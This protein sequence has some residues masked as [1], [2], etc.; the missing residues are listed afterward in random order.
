MAVVLPSHRFHAAMRHE[1]FLGLRSLFHKA[2]I[3]REPQAHR[4]LARESCDL[5]APGRMRYP[6]Q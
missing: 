6:N 5:G 3:E 1:V 2:D 4:C